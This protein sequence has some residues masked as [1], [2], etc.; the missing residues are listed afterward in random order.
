MPNFAVLVV[1]MLTT[2]G[3]S[4]LTSSDKDLSSL[5]RAVRV[6]AANAKQVEIM[7]KNIR[8]LADFFIFF[9]SGDKNRLFILLA[10]VKMSVKRC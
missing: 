8:S 9:T 6:L 10:R 2:D 7:V 3:L 1:L 5:D 4:L